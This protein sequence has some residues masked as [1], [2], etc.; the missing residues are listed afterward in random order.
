[1]VLNNN[2]KFCFLNI[3][4]FSVPYQP[5]WYGYIAFCTYKYDDSKLYKQFRILLQSHRK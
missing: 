5:R 2:I 3:Y 1:M 4:I